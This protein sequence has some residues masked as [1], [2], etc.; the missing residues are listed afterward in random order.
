MNLAKL[1]LSLYMLIHSVEIWAQRKE[2]REVDTNDHMMKVIH[3]TLGRSTVLSFQD[4]PV[5]VISGNSNYFNIEFI[6]NDLTIQPL[7]SVETNLFV[8]TERQSKYGFILR[9]GAVA[10]Y[11]DI[12]YIKWQS[13]LQV[14]TSRKKLKPQKV[15]QPF[16]ISFNKEL[17]LNVMRFL[18][19]GEMKTY[20]FDFDFL[21]MDKGKRSSS[22]VDIFVSRGNQRFLGQKIVWEKDEVETGKKIKGRLI[23]RVEQGQDFTLNVKIKEKGSRSIITKDY[24]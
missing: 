10:N 13:P 15:L 19:L 16:K 18:R 23:F 7:S 6:G 8:Y 1:M 5:K 24:L 20:L 4:K 3:L 17:E 9:V 14:M 11:D 22:S 2:V 12:V 21:N